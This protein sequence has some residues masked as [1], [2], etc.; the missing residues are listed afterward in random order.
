[1]GVVM[2]IV[3][4]PRAVVPM[5]VMGNC[6]PGVPSVAVIE[7]SAPTVM[8]PGPVMVTVMVFARPRPYMVTV[9][10]PCDRETV[11]P[12]VEATPEP[13]LTPRNSAFGVGLD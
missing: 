5:S 11:S 1:M 8:S 7:E 6:T 9:A 13:R 2:T 12:V 10:L 4:A 3:R